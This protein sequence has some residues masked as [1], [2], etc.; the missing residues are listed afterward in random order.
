MEQ[1]FSKAGGMLRK[2]LKKKGLRR[3]VLAAALA[4]DPKSLD[5]WTRGGK[6]PGTQNAYCLAALCWPEDEGTAKKY[7]EALRRTWDAAAWT[8]GIERAQQ[9][10]QTL[11]QGGPPRRARKNDWRGL[12]GP[13]IE[14]LL[15]APWDAKKE[16]LD[17]GKTRFR[18]ILRRD[19][20]IQA[21]RIGYLPWLSKDGEPTDE[22]VEYFRQAIRLNVEA[23]DLHGGKLKDCHLYIVADESFAEYG[24]HTDFVVLVCASCTEHDGLVLV[25]TNGTPHIYPHHVTGPSISEVI[26]VEQG[27]RNR[28]KDKE[29][30]LKLEPRI[31]GSIIG[32]V[33]FPRHPVRRSPLLLNTRKTERKKW[34]VGVPAWPDTMLILFIVTQAQSVG[35]LDIEFV[36]REEFADLRADLELGSIDAVIATE[37]AVEEVEGIEEPIDLYTYQGNLLYMEETHPDRDK[38]ER[39]FLD[40]SRTPSREEL[41]RVFEKK[42]VAVS[43]AADDEI[44]LLRFLSQALG[45][46]AEGTGNETS[47]DELWKQ[48]SAELNLK[49]VVV[50]AS[51]GSPPRADCLWWG[52]MK[53]PWEFVWPVT[54]PRHCPRTTVRLFR[55]L[56]NSSRPEGALRK[57]PE[58]IKEMAKHVRE[59]ETKALIFVNSK[60][61]YHIPLDRFRMLYT[62][63]VRQVKA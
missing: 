4:V 13:A 15:K 25:E 20:A 52:L 62:E 14:A 36:V 37:E 57:L 45:G 5:N 59:N 30:N 53:T 18:G 51:G 24:L 54:R 26:R 49:R 47:Q 63:A 43:D 35:D 10:Q 12:R 9:M 41:R 60:L 7:I 17:L 6:R 48:I 8:E 29:R 39:L 16:R 46:K 3:A 23:K 44:L 50:R 40:S 34:R 31:L 55:R 56:T 58:A 27:E 32:V 28:G 42:V 1:V 21:G 19:H 61:P 22:A 11:E 38:L 2:A 33:P